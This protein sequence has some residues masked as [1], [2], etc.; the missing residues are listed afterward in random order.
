MSAKGLLSSRLYLLPTAHF[1]HKS[2]DNTRPYMDYIY[3][4]CLTECLPL[5]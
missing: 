5:P 1:L 2:T 3:L 4:T